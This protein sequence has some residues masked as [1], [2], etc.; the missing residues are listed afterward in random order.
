VKPPTALNSIHHTANPPPPR[1]LRTRKGYEPADR[2]A[3]APINT[4]REKPAIPGRKNRAWRR[5][6]L[7]S[8]KLQ[9]PRWRDEITAIVWG[10]AGARPRSLEIQ[11]KKYHLS[12]RGVFPHFQPTA[13]LVLT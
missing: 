6:S 2:N 12:H 5:G 7:R 13:I 11:T 8:F 10:K 9:P 1:T 4:T 3:K